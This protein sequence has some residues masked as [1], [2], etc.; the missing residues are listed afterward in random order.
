MALGIRLYLQL[1]QISSP[2]YRVPLAR[3]GSFWNVLYS[4]DCILFRYLGNRNKLLLLAWIQKG[5]F[6]RR[7]VLLSQDVSCFLS[8]HEKVGARFQRRTNRRCTR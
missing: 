2:A 5:L 3:F 8:F 7:D 1:F 4:D 6:C